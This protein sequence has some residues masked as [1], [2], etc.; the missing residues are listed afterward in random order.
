MNE[1]LLE[2][3]RPDDSNMRSIIG[4]DEEINQVVLIEVNFTLFILYSVHATSMHKPYMKVYVKLINVVYM[5]ECF[6]TEAHGEGG[7]YNYSFIKN[8]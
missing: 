5:Y 4:S 6:P 2:S 3:S 1:H 8:E 7:I